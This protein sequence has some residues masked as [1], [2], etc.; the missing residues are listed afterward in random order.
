VIMCNKCC[1]DVDTDCILQVNMMYQ[2][3]SDPGQIRPILYV[4][5]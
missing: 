2:S 3:S 4:L 5:A 1:I